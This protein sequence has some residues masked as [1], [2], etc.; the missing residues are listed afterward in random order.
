MANIRFYF[1]LICLLAL[2]IFVANS[3]QEDRA[4]LRQ[5]SSKSTELNYSEFISYLLKM[6]PDQDEKFIAQR[7]SETKDVHSFLRSFVPYFYYLLKNEQ[8]LKNEFANVTSVEGAM[9]A[10]VH[11]LN[12]GIL[13]DDQAKAT[14]TINDYDDLTNGPVFFDV[15]RHLTSIKLS[16]FQLDIKKYLEFYLNGLVDKKISQNLLL[17]DLLKDAE[18]S[19][20]KLAKKIVELDGKPKF[21]KKKAVALEVTDEENKN[22][23][24]VLNKIS[25]FENI[26]VLDKYR[27]LKLSGGSA[28]SL[29]YEIIAQLKSGQVVYV[30][31]KEWK[32]SSFDNVFF[33][34]SRLKT[35]NRFQLLMDTVYQNKRNAQVLAVNMNGKDFLVSF[36]WKASEIF[37]WDDLTLDQQNSLFY[38]EAYSLGQF[39]RLGLQLNS[40]INYYLSQI[41][42]LD[43]QNLLKLIE[44]L[45]LSIEKTFN[46][47]PH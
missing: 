33:G 10:D 18:S 47:L 26:F 44:N 35:F 34:K 29:R 8:G 17:N 3:T 28:G 22:I 12:F 6:Y 36:N 21:K 42:K 46:Q 24:K 1:F 41:L 27:R 5:P 19:G 7:I 9:A 31:M 4:L 13:L 11:V 15:L 14:F 43:E 25:S 16:G 23:V 20:F 37:D 45:S 30:T 2:S 38:S 40:N 32:I 39:H